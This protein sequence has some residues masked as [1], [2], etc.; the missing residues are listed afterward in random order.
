MCVCGGV[1]SISKANI[2]N[3]KR[4]NVCPFRLGKKGKMSILKTSNQHCTT[5]LSQ[6]NK[7]RKKKR[8]FLK[9]KDGRIEVKFSLSINYM[10][11]YIEN[12]KE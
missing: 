1:S 12:T 11:V 6:Y 10:I 2:F 8:F 3:G 4:K 5:V 7:A 9:T